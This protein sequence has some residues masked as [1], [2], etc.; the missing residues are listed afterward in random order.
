[1]DREPQARCHS[2]RDFGRLALGAGAAAFLPFEATAATPPPTA[3][4]VHH[5][6]LP[7]FY[8]PY[9]EPWLRRFATNVDEVLAWTPERSLAAMEVAGVARSILSIS[10]PGVDTAA[11]E[12]AELARRCNDYAAALALRHPDRFRF[13]A[14]LPLPDVEASLAELDRALGLEGVVGAGLLSNHGGRYLGDPAFAPLLQALDRRGTL[15]YVHPTMAPCCAGL[16]ADVADP[17]IEFPVDTG[18]TISSLLWSGA[19]SRYP[20]IEW[21]F[22]HGGGILPMVIER[23]AAMGFVRPDLRAR[24]PEGPLAALAR[25]HVD[26]ASVA[27][28]PA[29]AAMRAWLPPDRILFGTDFPWGA[30]DRTLAALERLELPAELLAAIRRGNADRLLGGRA[31]RS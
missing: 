27:N 9:A 17:L 18:R 7:P 23:V 15:V 25:L 19:L 3:I 4:D 6:L 31:R 10:A 16:V 14:V 1:M 2:R 12:A 5:H 13:F 11:T 29:M 20:G 21:I 22:S 28:A 30:P 24:V 26:T 8:K